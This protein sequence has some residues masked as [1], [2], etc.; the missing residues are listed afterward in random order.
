MFGTSEYKAGVVSSQLQ[1][2]VLDGRKKLNWIL[3]RVKGLTKIQLARGRG[4]WLAF[5]NTI[6]DDWA[7]EVA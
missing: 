7:P 4:Q 2:S 3:I 1:C 5:M 6:M